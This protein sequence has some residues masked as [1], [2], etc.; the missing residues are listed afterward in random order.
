[1]NL[2]LA[3]IIKRGFDPTGHGHYGAKRGSKK[4]KGLDLNTA[5]GDE[6][7]SMISGKITKI[8]YCYKDALEFRYVEVT[9]L[10]YRVRLMYVAPSELKEGDV[11]SEGQLVGHSQDIAGH[12][13]NGMMNHLHVEVYKHELLTDPEPL[14]D[15]ILMSKGK[16][17]SYWNEIL[18][19]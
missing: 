3:S 12:W 19:I 15:L 6:V 1:M 17:F 7:F 9:N 2:P 14:I 10:T 11:I 18:K 8:G 4:H 13:G 5:P 16:E